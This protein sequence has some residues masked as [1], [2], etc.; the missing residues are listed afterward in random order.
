MFAEILKGSSI[1]EVIKET[2]NEKS[3][4]LELRVKDKKRWTKMLTKILTSTSED[5]DYGVAI[6][7]AYWA[8]ED[9]TIAFCWVLIVWGAL[10][11]AFE[12]LKPIL[13]QMDAA[14]VHHQPE[15]EMTEGQQ[16]RFATVLG[17]RSVQRP[18]GTVN[19]ETTI[20]LPHRG[21]RP[22]HGGRTKKLKDVGKPGMWAFADGIGGDEGGDPWY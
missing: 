11:V 19:E 3:V 4:K 12:D 20:A 17:R 6:N 14:P 7:K 1:L 16:R 18:D 13:A 21:P 8:K 22:G 2:V 10:D 5:D 9:K 15:M